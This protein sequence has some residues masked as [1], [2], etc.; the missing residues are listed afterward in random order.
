[1]ATYKIPKHI[2]RGQAGLAKL[3]GTDGILAGIATDLAA[4]KEKV[5][6]IVAISA[7]GAVTDIAS[8]KAALVTI[9]ALGALNTS[10]ES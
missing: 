10:V 9:A 8:L 1:M 3:G 2:G 4:L 6:A 5:D 7:D